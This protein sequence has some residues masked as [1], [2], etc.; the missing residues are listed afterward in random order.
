LGQVFRDDGLREPTFFRELA[1]G[2][3]T[4]A[5]LFNNPQTIRVRER[6]QRF[7]RSSSILGSMD[8]FDMTEYTIYGIYPSR[9]TYRTP[10]GEIN[11]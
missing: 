9:N 7:G 2:A 11:P 1:D 4:R 8:G 6:F 3:L 5:E 10:S